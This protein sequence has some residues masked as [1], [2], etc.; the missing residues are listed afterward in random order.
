MA[1]KQCCLKSTIEARSAFEKCAPLIELNRFTR[2]VMFQNSTNQSKICHRVLACDKKIFKFSD[3]S[4]RIVL[5]I[6]EL[7]IRTLSFLQM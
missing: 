3:E 4:P 1:I 2:D 5:L 7:S 6:A